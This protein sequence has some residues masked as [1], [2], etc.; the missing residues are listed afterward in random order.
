MREALDQWLFVAAAY[1]V[2]IIGT[3]L[4]AGWSWLAM[5]RA[6]ARRDKARGK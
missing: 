2:G 4:L 6:E 5:R 3:L 1:A